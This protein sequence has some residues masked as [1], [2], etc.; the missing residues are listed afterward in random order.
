M[1]K[2]LKI[3]TLA[4]MAA[5]ALSVPATSQA[6]LVS[7]FTANNYF[8]AITSDDD[9][10]TVFSSRT[11]PK[12]GWNAGTMLVYAKNPL[13]FGAPAGNRIAGVTNNTVIGNFYATYGILD[14]MSVGLN[15]PIWFWNDTRRLLSRN[16]DA[17]DP[18]FDSSMNLGDITLLFKFRL[19][20]NTDRLIG[21]ALIPFVAMPSGPSS[22]WAG[23]GSVSGGLIV[24]L[25]FN[26]HDRV[27]LALNVGGRARDKTTIFNATMDH[28]LLASLGLSIKLISRL[29][30]FLEGFMQPTFNDFFGNEVGIPAEALG[31]FKI[32]VSDRFSV[33]VGG[34]VGLTIG[35]GT[36]DWRAFL[37]LN[38]NWAPAPC[39]A[40]EAPPQVEAREIEI[41][42]M[43]HFA[44]DKAVI[45][46]QSYPILDD[47][48]SII[49][50]NEA[51]I[52][53]VMVEG[54]TDSIGSDAY[55]QRLSDRRAASVKTYLVNK[56]I[57]AGMLDTVG[58]GESKP[59]ATNTTAEGRAKNRR[60]QFKVEGR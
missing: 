17:V 56:G 28:Q 8:P 11:I 39:P 40:C 27:N 26:I 58:Y 49:K 2:R 3:F 9:M 25:D 22:V 37:G 4:L 38:Y 35:I 59:I 55:N 45:R 50:S 57:S 41:S 18:N 33:R 43:I 53:K 23:N 12:M 52:S 5:V 16:P 6:Q 60:V 31:G 1:N 10:L 42:Q 44:F 20:D 19:R 15:I 32:K 24:V 48:A 7:G 29:F 51:S 14:W 36:P 13:E 34:G 47:V 21:V 30:L 46:P 54:H